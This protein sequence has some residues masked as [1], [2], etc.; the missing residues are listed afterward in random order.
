MSDRGWDNADFLE[1]LSGDVNKR[2]QAADEY[3]EFSEK[4][5]AHMKRQMEIMKTPQG[6]AFLEQQQLGRQ[7]QMADGGS[8]PFPD[9]AIFDNVQP[10]SGGGSRMSQMMAQAGKMKD[11]K[12][13]MKEM[14]FEQKFAVPLDDDDD[15]EEDES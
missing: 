9:D 12:A 6:M 1:G 8:P 14:G 7:Q 3:R 2:Q 5:R 4:R 10:G 15:E 11:M 13:Q